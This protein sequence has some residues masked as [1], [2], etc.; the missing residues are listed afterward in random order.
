MLKTYY[1]LGSNSKLNL[2]I[3]DISDFSQNKK[4]GELLVRVQS[5]NAKTI[6]PQDLFQ[7][8]KLEDHL[9]IIRWQLSWKDKLIEE[10]GYDRIHINVSNK[11]LLFSAAAEIFIKLLKQSPAPTCFEFGS[12]FPINYNLET[13]TV[14]GKIRDMG[15]GSALDQYGSN[16]ISSP[17]LLTQ[18]MF[19]TVKVSQDYILDLELKEDSLNR[20]Y[21]D[22]AERGLA[23]IAEGVETE[24]QY[25]II[26]NAGFS[27]F[28]GY[29]FDKPHPVPVGGPEEPTILE[30]FLAA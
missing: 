29:Y 4:E 14:L 2:Y 11:I 17:L 1:N 24:E 3:Q 8:M 15:H 27:T 18:Q 12:N 6:T 5:N 28:Q 13:N 26:S 7:S 23:S 25:T 19:D 21:R 30:L 20:F 9:N 10:E 22:L 16:H